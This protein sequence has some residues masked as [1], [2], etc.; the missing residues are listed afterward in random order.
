MNG[1]PTPVIILPSLDPDDA[2]AGLVSALT[3]F[4]IIIVD[5]GSSP[6]H[7]KLFDTLE[8]LENCTVCRHGENKGKGAALKTAM[9]H[10]LVLS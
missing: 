10:V 1:A 6:A 9:R 3:A 2:L 5:D 7:A 8:I 4:H